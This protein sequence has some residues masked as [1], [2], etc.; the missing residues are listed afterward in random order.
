MIVTVNSKQIIVDTTVKQKD[1]VPV[2]YKDTLFVPVRYLIDELNVSTRI[3][4]NTGIVQIDSEVF[5]ASKLI[6]M[7]QEFD[8]TP[9][10]ADVNTIVPLS[11]KMQM[12]NSKSELLTG[13]LTITAKN[14]SNDGI[15]AGKED[16]HVI[17]VYDQAIAMET[18]ITTADQS[19]KRE[20][21]ELKRDQTFNRTIEF[22]APNDKEKLKYIF[23][24]GRTFE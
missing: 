10:I 4:S 17:F 6:E 23:A 20:R 2:L 22:A 9:P 18:D 16:L 13:Q 19:H 21:P 14:V 3:D 5:A 11:Y 1:T 15:E 12:T 24:V 7:I 8:R